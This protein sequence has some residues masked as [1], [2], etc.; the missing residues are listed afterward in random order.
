MRTR[1][2]A[3]PLVM[4]A[5]C[6][7]FAQAASPAANGGYFRSQ[8]MPP[9]AHA[10]CARD[11][12]PTYRADEIVTGT[13]MRQRPWGFAQALREVLVKA[14]GDPRLANDARTGSLAAHADRFVACFAYADL[15]AGVPL[16]DD[17]GTYDRP[18]RLT[19]VFAPAKI[20]ALLLRFGDRP[21]RGARPV[22]VPVLLVDGRKPPPYLLSA[23]IAA[24]A[25]ERGA[26]AVAAQR[27]GM[28]VHIPTEAELRALG[29]GA[30]R[31]PA[32]LPPSNAGEAVVLGTLDWHEA[33]PGWVGRWRMRR[34]RGRYVWGIA[35]VNY[36]AAFRNIVRGVML[37]ASGNG[38][39]DS[40][41]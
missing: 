35:G 8:L 28:T 38:P 16:H 22:V 9:A 34:Q 30:A 10:A 17:Q 25:E 31:L 29:A 37:A 24:G 6:G 11:S 32:T 20:D 41:D 21:W 27:Y 36:D 33:L 26:F 4:T 7:A 19:V 18:Y 2:A 40:G 12:G 39:P 1:R 5:L 23:E 14:S 3:L 15:L 13:D